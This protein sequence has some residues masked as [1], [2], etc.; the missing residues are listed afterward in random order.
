VKTL[1]QLRGRLRR[2]LGPNVLRSL[3]SEGRVP[4]RRRVRP[5]EPKNET[6]ARID[7]VWSLDGS[8]GAIQDMW[9]RHCSHIFASGHRVLL[10]VNLNTPHPYPGSTCPEMLSFVIDLIGRAGA[11]EILVGDCS[12]NRALPTRSVA[13]KM[14]I[15]DVIEGRARMVCFDEGPWVTVSLTTPYLTEVTVPRLAFEVDRIIGLANMK[16]HVRADFSFGM[17]LCVGF[18]HPVERHGLHRDHLQERAVEILKAIE[19]DVTV[20]DGR[21]AF[22]TGG[23]ETGKTVDAGVVLMGTDIVAVDLEAYRVLYRLK[24]EHGCL[25][26]FSED[27]FAMAQFRHAAAL[28]LC[29]GV[30]ENY[31]VDVAPG[32]GGSA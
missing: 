19:P 13:K 22:V 16:T 26:H 24:K 11:K 18:M 5:V 20:I 9:N 3:E 29:G 21:R 7:N 23:P 27:L 14:G 30:S 1:S 6:V 17:K 25:D 4:L 15:L 10:K 32:D 2:A 28:G 31:L 12:S 8:R